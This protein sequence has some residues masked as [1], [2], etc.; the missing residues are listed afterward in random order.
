[1]STHAL[2]E[3][4]QQARSL[5][6]CCSDPL[7]DVSEWF[8]LGEITNVHW[9]IDAGITSA[10]AVAAARSTAIAFQFATLRSMSS[11]RAFVLHITKGTTST[12]LTGHGG[13]TRH[14]WTR[15]VIDSVEIILTTRRLRE[16][17]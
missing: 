16:V 2:G 10:I 7:E 14:P 12:E 11:V 15:G 4:M 1:M 8:Y 6:F 17:I 5:Y 13:P 9:G 3:Q